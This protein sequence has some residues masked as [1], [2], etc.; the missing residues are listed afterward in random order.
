M[1]PKIQKALAMVAESRPRMNKLTRAEREELER[2]ARRTMAGACPKCGAQVMD[3]FAGK[4]RIHDVD[5][6]QG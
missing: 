6:C 1:D 4:R 5:A 3:P 2:G